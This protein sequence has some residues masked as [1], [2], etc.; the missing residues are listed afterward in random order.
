MKQ[1]FG[2]LGPDCLLLHIPENPREMEKGYIG[3]EIIEG[4][5]MLFSFSRAQLTPILMDG[6]KT[7]LDVLWIR[8]GVVDT[9]VE[10]FFGRMIAAVGEKIIE[11]PAGY[12]RKKGIKRGDDFCLVEDEDAQRSN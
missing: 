12:V 9:I 8:D 4:E 6:M 3:K 2:L 1:S 10:Q 11:L 7:S 5:G